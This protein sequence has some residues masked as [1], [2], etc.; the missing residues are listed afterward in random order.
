MH[1]SGQRSWQTSQAEQSIIPRH[2]RA[3]VTASSFVSPGSGEKNFLRLFCP[4]TFCLAIVFWGIS[5]AFILF[6]RLGHSG[7]ETVSQLISL[8]L[9]SNKVSGYCDTTAKAGIQVNQRN[10]NTGC[11]IK[12]GMTGNKCV[13][14]STAFLLLCVW[15]NEKC[16][17]IGVTTETDGWIPPL[18]SRPRWPRW[19]IPDR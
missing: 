15:A 9:C 19:P 2:R 3:A 5:Q 17:F 12:S 6:F 8:L 7:E 13:L 14:S 1:S 10:K 18:S 4:G 16:Y 11:R